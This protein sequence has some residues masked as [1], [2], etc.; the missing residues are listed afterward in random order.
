MPCHPFRSADGKTTGFICT[1]T[2][3]RRCVG[4]SQ[5][6]ATYRLCD[7]RLKSKPG[8]TCDAVVCTRCTFEPAAEKDLCPPHAAAWLKRGEAA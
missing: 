8:K 2:R 7:A 1:R 3:R 4:C 6:V 5:L